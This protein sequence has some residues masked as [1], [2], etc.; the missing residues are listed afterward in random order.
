MVP[1]LERTAAHGLPVD[2]LGVHVKDSLHAQSI[3]EMIK[4]HMFHV[5]SLSFQVDGSLP[6]QRNEV[7]S[8]LET[9]APMLRHFAFVLE[10][11]LKHGALP[12]RKKV[13]GGNAPLLEQLELREDA[14]MYL[15]A[16]VAFQS[17]RSIRISNVV[18]RPRDPAWFSLLE[19]MSITDLELST[20][21]VESTSQDKIQ[22]PRTL[23]HLRVRFHF[24]EELNILDM[25]HIS[26]I[27]T[28]R[29]APFLG[30]LLQAD[31]APFIPHDLQW[32]PQALT[33]ILGNGD[34]SFR[35]R[36]GNDQQRRRTRVLLRVFLRVETEARSL[37][38]LTFGRV[39]S[40]TLYV[41]GDLV[42]EWPK[43]YHPGACTS[44]QHLTIATTAWRE[45][46]LAV[47]FTLIRTAFPHLRTL[48][49]QAT[50][51]SLP[52]IIHTDAL[53]E[54]IPYLSYTAPKLEELCLRGIIVRPAC[55]PLYT[56]AD[57]VR[58]EEER[59]D[60]V[61]DLWEEDSD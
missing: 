22:L 32:Q 19:F 24:P 38:D 59:Y 13:F 2:L 20:A 31:V 10:D 56:V 11:H 52:L 37:W 47:E 57:N 50:S 46:R 51:F 14:W 44:V 61:P 26:T 60:I 23:K 6:R 7:V 21:G 53:P 54:A 18:M 42:Q 17:I 35:L 25:K 28:V 15:W 36:E 5:R 3:C 45:D 43:L 30:M 27:P 48:T 49:L 9:P 55:A 34:I 4:K 29:L 33:A 12:F 8:T 41:C 1:L 58:L 40:V 16:F 39:A